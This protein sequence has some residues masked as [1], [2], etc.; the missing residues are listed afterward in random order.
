MRAR[1][2]VSR[3]I[4]LSRMSLNRNE[5][6]CPRVFASMLDQRVITRKRCCCGEKSRGFA[7]GF[8]EDSRGFVLFFGGF[9]ATYEMICENKMRLVYFTHWAQRCVAGPSRV[10]TWHCGAEASP[11]LGPATSLCA[12]R[13]K[14]QKLCQN[15]HETRE[16]SGAPCNPALNIGKWAMGNGRGVSMNRGGSTTFG[17]SDSNIKSGVAKGC[18]AAGLQRGGEH[19]Q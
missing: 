16:A 15:P 10:R 18:G 11:S 9:A 7:G 8:A 17:A 3:A 5:H 1:R 6:V 4:P 2:V 12:Q 14:P 19:C 13:T